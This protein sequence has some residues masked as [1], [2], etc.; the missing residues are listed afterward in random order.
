MHPT[1]VQ[2]WLMA[3]RWEADGDRKG[4]GG[5]NTE[6]ARRICMRALR[7]LKGARGE[8][9][10]WGEWVRVEV[11]Y[12]ER[13]RRRWEVLGIG[14]GVEVGKEEKEPVGMEVDEEGEKEDAGVD[15]KEIEGK[16]GQ[17]ASAVLDQAAKAVE[18]TAVSGQEAIREGAVVRLVLDSCLTSYNHSLASYEFLITLL[19][20]LPSSLRLPLLSHIYSSLSTHHPTNATA[21]TLLCTRYMHDF[22]YDSNKKEDSQQTGLEGEELVDCVGRCVEEFW[23]ACKGKKGKGKEREKVS[24]EVWESFCGWLEEVEEESTDENLTVFL[25]TTLSTAL[26]LSPPSPSL[27]LLSLRHLIRNSAAPS[28]I[29]SCATTLTALF[30]N[31]TTTDPTTASQS[32]LARLEVSLSLAEHFTPGTL[33]PIFESAVKALPYSGQIWSLYASSLGT[34]LAAPVETEEVEKW[35]T[36]AIGRALLTSALPPPT[37]VQEEEESPRSILPRL[38]LEFLLSSSTPLSVIGPKIE[39]LLISAP[40][41]PISFLRSVLSL[42]EEVLGKE[43]KEKVWERVLRHKD[44]SSGEW[45][46]KAKEA[47]GQGRVKD[48]NEVVGRAM[49]VLKGRNKGEFEGE[50]A[51]VCD[52]A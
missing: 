39:A 33:A 35:F 38:F 28:T 11:G 40:T 37:F 47:L 12:V 7:F 1:H 13:V 30:G 17:H 9:E 44:C 48:A 6:G 16:E 51:R 21:T 19:R 23:K 24:T 34:I 45:L 5:G 18:N 8:E 32:W 46:E 4:M 10:V 3:S 27:S 49:R 31:P 22:P 26:S 20:S 50:W 42:G 2:Y 25:T 36:A 43:R 14:K 41:L 15:L 52:G 29:L